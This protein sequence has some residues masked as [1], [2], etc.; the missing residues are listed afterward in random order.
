MVAKL[1]W[2][3]HKDLVS[4]WRA[5]R[6]WPAMLLF[7]AVVALMFSV[8]IDPIPERKAQITGSLLW[9]AIFLYIARLHVEQ[10]RL[11]RGLETLQSQLQ[12]GSE[13]CTEY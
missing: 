12:D 4:E 6:A 9:L 1:W 13:K 7:G 5:R 10:R 8:Q 11:T 3:I 2:M